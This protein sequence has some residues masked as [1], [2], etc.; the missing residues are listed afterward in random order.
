MCA[1]AHELKRRRNEVIFFALADVAALLD[2]AGLGCEIYGETEFPLGSLGA[3]NRRQAQLTGLAALMFTRTRLRIFMEVALRYLPG[4]IKSAGLD[5]LVIDR[6]SG[7]CGTI[8]D[9]CGF[10]RTAD[11]VLEAVTTKRPVL[12]DKCTSS[13]LMTQYPSEETDH[14]GNGSSVPGRAE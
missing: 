5:G 6:V 4:D 7:G 10:A 11:I 12:R 13:N 1:L 2:S 8:A 3:V 14:E 9:Y